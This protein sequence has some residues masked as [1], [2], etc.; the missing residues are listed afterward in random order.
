MATMAVED[1]GIDFEV[2]GCEDGVGRAHVAVADAVKDFW[3][4]QC[5]VEEGCAA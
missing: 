5:A 3:A 2:V 4:H 1:R